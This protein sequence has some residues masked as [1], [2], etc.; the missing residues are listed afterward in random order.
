MQL[1]TRIN[2]RKPFASDYFRSA[3]GYLTI[4]LAIITLCGLVSQYFLTHYLIKEDYGV[5]IWIGTIMVLLNPF[6]LPGISTSII[7]SVAKGFD[8]NFRRG[9]W[10][11]MVGG[12]IGGVVLIGFG[13]YYWFWT[14]D[15]TKALIFV[16][17]GVLG[18]GL[19]LDTHQ[20]FWIGKKNFKALFWWAVPV[21]IFQ[22]F[23]TVA[24]LIISPNPVLVFSMQTVIQV[25]SNIGAAVGIMIF[26]KL[27]NEFSIKFQ[28]YGWFSSFL[29]IFGTIGSQV[30]KV[31]IGTFF[32]LEKLA[33]FAVAELINYYLF[34]IP[35]NLFHQIFVPHFAE[36]SLKDGS[37]WI[38]KQLP[39]LFISTIILLFMV[40]ISLPT[41]YKIL[42][43]SKYVDSIYY[44]HLFLINVLVS[45]PVLFVE[46][47]IKSHG[48]KKESAIAQII[49]SLIPLVL[50]FPFAFLWGLKGIVFVRIAQNI[51]LSSY[52]YY[53]IRRT[54]R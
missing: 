21:R 8:G 12:T 36:K 10:L 3:V 39:F 34:K 50:I 4:K 6:G 33:I 17:A 15:D 13:T 9:T 45:S 43:S 29:Y 49:I 1:S 2:W 38:Y 52:Y 30:D 5:L 46:A 40:G 32:G 23:T 19:W 25:A 16:V 28:S 18:P 35:K 47:L 53:F 51:T 20:C 11:E 48:L 24:V 7:G 31:V 37:R 44:A 42:F 22:L 27:N 14:H 26:G 41:V 54:R